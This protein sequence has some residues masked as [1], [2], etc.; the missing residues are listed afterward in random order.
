MFFILPDFSQHLCNQ[1]NW[2]K[3]IFVQALGLAVCQ[4]VSAMGGLYQGIS[5]RAVGGFLGSGKSTPDQLDQPGMES[6]LSLERHLSQ[7][8][9]HCTIEFA[10]DVS[11]SQ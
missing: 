9:V 2:G 8:H 1:P 4:F 10:W 3:R 11:G 5:K 6:P 7:Q